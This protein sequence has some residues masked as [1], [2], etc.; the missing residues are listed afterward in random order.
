MQKHLLATSGL[1]NLKRRTSQI[2]DHYTISQ[3]V[4]R[5]AKSGLQNLKRNSTSNLSPII[6][7]R[8]PTVMQKLCV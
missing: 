1:Q 6:K 7:I 8:E 4:A 5:F 3:N 2:S